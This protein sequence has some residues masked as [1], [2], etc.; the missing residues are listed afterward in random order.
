[1]SD[2]QENEQNLINQYEEE[3]EREINQ[4]IIDSVREGIQYVDR[5][6]RILKVNRQMCQ[7]MNCAD[8]NDVIGCSLEEWQE[9][10]KKNTAES[11]E[12]L[13]F[14]STVIKG[15]KPK[16][17]VI[18]Y[19]FTTNKPRFIQMYY[20]KIEK[21]GEMIGAIFVHR[22]ITKE[23]EIDQMKSELVST[24]SHELRTPLSSVLGFTELMLYRELKPERQK[25]YLM[26][27]YKEAKRLTTLINDFLDVQRMEAGK[28]TYLKKFVDIL[29]V[30]E[31]VIEENKVNSK[32][33][34]FLL[35]QCTFNTTVFADKDKIKQV[36]TNIVSNAVKYSPDGGEVRITV[37]IKEKHL[38]IAVSDEGLGIPEEAISKLF[39]KFYRIDSSNDQ[40]IGGTGLGLAISKEIMKAHEGEITIDSVEG[41]GSTFTILFPIVVEQKVKHDDSAY[42]EKRPTIFIVE[43]DESLALL[44]KEELVR[45]GFNVYLFKSGE[46]AF[47]N[48]KQK[49]PSAI[50]LDIMLEKE[51]NGWEF[52]EKLKENPFF[53]N[54]PIVI[55]TALDENDYSKSV[56]AKRFFLKPYK[57][58]ELIKVLH[59]IV[60]EQEDPSHIVYFNQPFL[61]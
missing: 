11:A 37:Q 52:I 32:K 38:A 14:F 61:E 59:E 12:V 15:E 39:T 7:F 9:M 25:K 43:D 8:I 18:Q 34:V 42:N 55:S 53:E 21:N 40:R 36:I 60:K 30:I 3:V 35:K 46:E 20:E 33:H 54:I 27:I 49:T 51:M 47:S 56:G 19:Q 58:N 13:Q 28:Q 31:E 57:P 16:S 5:K 45:S 6:G 1:M 24:V 10:F 26:T 17:E 41:K 22:D 44:L 2:R 48:I 23:Y 4:N 50:V 29:P